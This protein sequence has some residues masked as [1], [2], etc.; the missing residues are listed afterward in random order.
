MDG[1]LRERRARDGVPRRDAARARGERHAKH[2]DA[3]CVQE[4]NVKE[5]KGGPARAAHRPVDRPRAAR[6][7]GPRR[8]RGRRLDHGPR[9]QGGP[10]RL[11]LPR[12]ACATR[13]TSRR[14][15]RRTVLS[16]DLQDEIGP[17]PRLHA[18]RRPPLLRALHARLLPP[19]VASS[20][21]FADRF[22]RR[23]LEAARARPPRRAAIE[24]RGPRGFE[25]RAGR[26]HSRRRRPAG[27]RRRPSSTCSR[28]RRPR[29]CPL[30]DELADAGPRAP[31]PR[32]RA[33]CARRRDAAARLRRR[34]PLAR[35]R[36]PRAAGDARDGLP[37]AATCRSSRG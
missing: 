29:A 34:P 20:P 22:V 26:L 7:P 28:R 17:P 21:E 35:A 32:G 14:A 10:P 25:V 4:P 36:G 30:S 11:R 15:A 2:E 9:A 23:D 33:R 1:L 27:R 37:R 13:P 19:R 18:A 16:L 6:R 8:P 31:R 5:G 12:A 3:V 24:A